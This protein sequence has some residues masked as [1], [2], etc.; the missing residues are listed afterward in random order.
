MRCQRLPGRFIKIRLKTPR[1]DDVFEYFYLG[2]GPHVTNRGA[3]SPVS[4]K[5]SRQSL[6]RSIQIGVNVDSDTTF[7]ITGAIGAVTLFGNG[8]RIARMLSLISGLG[9]RCREQASGG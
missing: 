3:C 6:L 8:G 4:K 2:I 9:A 7:G 1:S 5:E